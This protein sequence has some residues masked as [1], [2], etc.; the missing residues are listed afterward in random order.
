MSCLAV[1]LNI[2]LNQATQMDVRDP[3]ADEE[4]RAK[5]LKVVGLFY[6]AGMLLH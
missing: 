6:N 4:Y 3:W 5:I 1:R 2:A